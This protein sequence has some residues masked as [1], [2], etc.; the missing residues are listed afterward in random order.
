MVAVKIL[1]TCIGISLALMPSAMIKTESCSAQNKGEA[2]CAPC[3][4]VDVGGIA[5]EYHSKADGKQ[6]HAGMENHTHHFK[7]NQSLVSSSPPCFCFWKRD[8]IK[9]TEGNTPQSGAV[10]VADASGGGLAK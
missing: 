2:K 9:V 10:K 6:P 3:K 5:Y 1:S 4:P 7:M 8:Y